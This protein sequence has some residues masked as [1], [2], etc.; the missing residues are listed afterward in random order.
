MRRPWNRKGLWGAIGAVV[1]VL[2]AGFIFANEKMTDWVNSGGLGAMLDQ[3]TSK[4]LKFEAHYSPLARV[5]VFGLRA[6]S[7]SGVKGSKTIVS[8][9]ANDISGTFDPL[10]IPLHRW[11]VDDIHIKSGSVMLQKTEAT[12]GAKSLGMPWWGLFWP[13]RVHLEDVKVDDANIL[14]QLKEKESGI[15]DTFLEITP[16]G[17]DFEY[18]ARGG[19]FKTPL[20]PTLEVQHAHLLIRKPRLYCTEFVLGD[21]DAHP[22]QQLKIE[23]DAGLQEDRSMKLKI[24]LNALSVSP[25][26]PVKLRGHVLGHASGHFDF[27]STGTGLETA[28]GQGKMTI[29]D[30]VLHELAPVHQYVVITG[31]P[32]PGDMA[33]K[34][35]EAD[36]SLK[37]GAISAQ[38]IDVE[39]EGV[40]RLQGSLSIAKDQTLSGTVE[41]GL[42]DPYLKWLPT[43]KSAIFTRAEGDYH[44]ATIHFSGTAKKPEQDLS[45]RV[46]QEISKSPTL[47]LKLFF[48]QAGDW[49]NFDD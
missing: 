1:I 48:N 14:W 8:L 16:N 17:H 3:E 25:W 4:G 35:C 2:V 47:A 28:D 13:Y 9:Q 41:L 20:S 31:S 27:S 23:G 15:Y 30:G 19:K 38:S 11:Q 45:T 42:T 40:F 37:E 29:A 5:G 6:D 33:L 18:D 32:D 46:A 7:F 21:D 39:S 49:F 34:V 43:A 12:P 44:F 26:M 24:D 10:G 22:E 36:V